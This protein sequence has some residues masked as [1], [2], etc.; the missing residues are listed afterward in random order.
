MTSARF[1]NLGF[2]PSLLS[3]ENY[4]CRDFGIP[5]Q[6]TSHAGIDWAVGSRWC[7]GYRIQHMSNAGLSGSNPGLNIQMLS[8]SFG[9]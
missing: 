8:V 6:I 9:F 5:F 2:S 4:D 1:L 3:R 7:F